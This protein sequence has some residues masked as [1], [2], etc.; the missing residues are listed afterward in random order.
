MELTEQVAR[1]AGVL[2][3]ARCALRLISL[4]HSSAFLDGCA[5]E[6]IRVLGIEG[7]TIDGASIVPDSDAIADFS[8]LGGTYS[9]E[10]SIDD[11]R[12]FLRKAGRRGML[13]EFTL[14]RETTR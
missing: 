2:V 6:R 13:F 5:S 1:R 8:S 11:A 14:K 7:F 4:E 3:T 10:E 9:V 12:R